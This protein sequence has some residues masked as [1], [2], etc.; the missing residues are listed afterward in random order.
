MF[1]G[2]LINDV[3]VYFLFVTTYIGVDI[4]FRGCFTGE[5][6]ELPGVQ[7][8]DHHL[9]RLLDRS[10]GLGRALVIAILHGLDLAKYLV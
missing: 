2:K 6:D 3:Q 1:S 9:A 10:E 5:S 4:Y 8:P 7:L